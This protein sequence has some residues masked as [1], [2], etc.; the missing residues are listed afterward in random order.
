MKIVAFD[1]EFKKKNRD[2]KSWK[3]MWAV[4]A[5]MGHW[6]TA[7]ELAPWMSK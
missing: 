6:L 7:E 3:Q 4:T 5:A 2:E 1:N